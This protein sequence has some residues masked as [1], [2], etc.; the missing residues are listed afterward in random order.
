MLGRKV[1]YVKCINCSHNN[2]AKT[3]LL[4]YKKQFLFI[5]EIFHANKSFWKIYPL[6][7]KYAYNCI[8]YNLVYFYNFVLMELVLH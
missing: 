6:K 7:E 4:L 2:V 3:I 1:S 5:Q 8:V